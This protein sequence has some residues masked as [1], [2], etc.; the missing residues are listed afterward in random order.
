MKRIGFAALILAMGLAIASPVG[1]A[2]PDC[3]ADPS[4]PSCKEAPPDSS[5]ELTIEAN[6]L[7]VQEESDT[8]IYTISVD[9]PSTDVELTSSLPAE[10]VESEEGVFRQEYLVVSHYAGFDLGADR[11]ARRQ[12]R[13]G[14][15]DDGVGP[16]RCPSGAA[17]TP[18]G[19]RLHLCADHVVAVSPSAI[20]ARSRVV[21]IGSHAGSDRRARGA[22]ARAQG[23]RRHS[24]IDDLG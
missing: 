11:C 14:D 24:G 6:L 9:P 7:W 3:E 21:A 23:S 13:G 16:E 10:L 5:V 8:I 12:Q 20:D 1:A 4:H 17:G 15:A 22:D 18:R 2:K 19:H